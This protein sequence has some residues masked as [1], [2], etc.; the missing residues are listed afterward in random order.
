MHPSSSILAGFWRLLRGLLV[1][2]ICGVAMAQQS[3]GLVL[4]DAEDEGVSL[5]PYLTVLED[6]NQSLSIKQIL[7]ADRSNLF[8]SR[9][10]TGRSLNFGLSRSA[11]WLK[12]TLRNDSRMPKERLIEIAYAHHDKVALYQPQADGH[13]QALHTGGDFPFADRPYPSRFFVLPVTIPASTEQ[14]LYLRM[15]S[16]SS[17]DIP[18]TLWTHS[19][20]EQHQRIDY[21]GQAWYFGMVMA[22]SLFNLLLFLALRDRAY[23]LYVGFVTTAALSLACYNGVAYEFLWPDLSHWS[24][25]STMVLFATCTLLLVLFAR[26]LME[27]KLYVPRFDKLLKVF[28]VLN[29]LQVVG[30][31]ISFRSTLPIAILIDSVCMLML[32][33]VSI[34]CVFK[35]QRSAKYFLAAFTFLILAA[36][37]TGMRSFGL[38]PTNFLTVNG[39]QFGSALEMLLLA[40]ALAERF[41]AIRLEKEK[42]QAEALSVNLA[43][44]ETL[45]SSERLLEERVEQRTH[46]LI[47]ANDRLQEQEMA[48]RHAM[49]VAEDASRLKSEFLANM[50]HEIRTPMNAV[51]GMAFLALK[52]DLTAKQRDYVSKIHIAGNSL[53]AVINDVLDFTK[54]EAGKLDM[55]Q[56]SFS[57]DEV[58]SNVATVT[59][60]KAQ[61]KQ[62][63]YLFQIP[64]EVPRQLIGDPLRLGQVLINL[65]NNAIKFTE[66]G[67]IHLSCRVV[68]QTQAEVTLE[69]VVR[70]TGIG[71]TESQA[72]NLFQPFMQADGSTTRKYGGTGLGLAICRRLVNM[73]GG[74][75]GLIS[76]SGKGST[77]HFSSCFGLASTVLPI[78]SANL[79]AWKGLHALVADDNHVACEILVDALQTLGIHAE[80]AYDGAE[81]LQILRQAD[82]KRPYQ[83]FFC[84]WKMPEMDGLEVASQLHTLHLRHRPHFILV[85]AFGREEVRQQVE[86]T[87]VDGIMTKPI[88]QASLAETLATVLQSPVRVAIQMPG[89]QESAPRWGG[90]RILLAEDNEVNQQ[91][92]IELLHS[93]GL[94]ID[95]AETGAEALTML[96]TQPADYYKLVLMDVQMPEMDGHEATLQ[97]RSMA[98]FN[99]LPIVAMTAH[100]MVEERE[101]C[102]LEGM[103]D[104]ITK[105]ID[106]MRMFLTL[107]KWLPPSSAKTETSPTSPQET[108]TVSVEP[109]PAVPSPEPDPTAKTEVVL[110]GFDTE[111]ALRRMGGR[112]EFYHRMLAKLPKTL[113]NNSAALH[114]ALADADRATAERIAHTTLGVAANVG[115]VELADISRT[116]EQALHDG[117][118][119]SVMLTDFDTCLAG[120]L[121]QI[122]VNFPFST[123]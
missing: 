76:S 115:A 84:D 92:A 3:K 94:Q 70:D 118:E 6:H 59:A 14:T 112:L 56:V 8:E 107:E 28:I 18:A 110:K 103:Q 74:E 68:R 32:L 82:D 41:N 61:D 60:Q 89:L 33:I 120:V 86:F 29:P 40:F 77:F 9:A 122:E 2:A 93:E 104:V 49:H 119:T 20:Y 69:F 98:R 111:T 23:L 55:E 15:A 79:Q 25:I 90:E 47:E 12:L 17:M 21:I 16:D 51:I 105:P 37:M 58:L 45:Q 102:L 4:G 97:I 48:L 62:L 50:S 109:E 42:A 19:A 63:E 71:M 26:K 91:I 116:L 10:G 88:N 53:L 39:M 1:L 22:M 66:D 36:A 72:A 95:V 54:I 65:A 113:G 80:V 13:Y 46:E 11:F 85:T 100:A 34:A 87:V 108:S 121:A 83:L 52:T 64:P 99:D 38:V 96:Q 101:R 31:M 106:P 44:V 43:L 117:N 5:L 73:M 30:L 57:L 24:K 78:S 114:A 123:H 75:I 7:A 81:A 67:E 27:T 35:G